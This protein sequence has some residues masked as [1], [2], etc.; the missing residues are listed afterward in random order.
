[1]C[2]SDYQRDYEARKK[3]RET[4]SMENLKEELFIIDIM[5]EEMKQDDPRL[6]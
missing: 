1:M 2:N 5:R 6:R 3:Y 4:K